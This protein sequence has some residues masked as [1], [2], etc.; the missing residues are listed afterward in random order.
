MGRCM[1]GSRRRSDYAEDEKQ[2]RA[3]AKLLGVPFDRTAFMK[4]HAPTAEV[5]GEAKEQA[6]K[7]SDDFTYKYAQERDEKLRP[8]LSE[9]I[10][11]LSAKEIAAE[12]TKR[13]IP[14]ANTSRP[15]PWGRG[16]VLHILRR[17]GI[18][19]VLTPAKRKRLCCPV[20][21]PKAKPQRVKGKPGRPLKSVKDKTRV[22][23]FCKSKYQY[24]DKK[25]QR[26]CGLACYWLARLNRES[27]SQR[28]SSSA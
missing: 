21:A 2:E 20:R 13:R 15:G 25:R 10:K 9:L 6:F 24:S 3:L 4:A 28:S 16:G 11:T 12:L 26:F 23:E 18:S 1:A 19:A 27:R 8:L 17:L 22:C 14:K 7:A 5:P